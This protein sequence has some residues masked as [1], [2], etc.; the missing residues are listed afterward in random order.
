MPNSN[1][2]QTEQF[3]DALTAHKGTTVSRGDAK[4]IAKAAG[5]PAPRWFIASDVFRAGRGTYRKPTLAEVTKLG[6]GYPAKGRP[7]KS[8][9][10][11]SSAP[12]VK[13]TLPRTPRTVKAPTPAATD[14]TVLIKDSTANTSMQQ[15]LSKALGVDLLLGD[16]ESIPYVP[17]V[18][19]QYV[20]WGHFDTVKTILE[21]GQFLPFM[22]VGPSGNGKTKM[23]EQVCA[24]IGREFVRCNITAQTDEDDMLGGFRLVNGETKYVLGPVPLAMM[25]G[26]FL[27][28]DE[29]DLGTAAMMCLQPVLEGNAL[30]LKK[31]NKYILPAPGF[32]IGATSNTKGRGDD[33]K[34]AHTTIMNEA[35]LERFAVMFEQT[36]PE[37][38]TERKILTN[39]LKSLGVNDTTLAKHLVEFATVTRTNYANGLS[40]DEIATRRLLHIVRGYAALRDINKVMALT[41]ARFDADTATAF[42]NLWDAIHV[43]PVANPSPSGAPVPPVG[44]FTATNTTAT[45]AAAPPADINF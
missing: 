27:L 11:T 26:S 44:T 36:W 20:P 30:Y 41:L 43:D 28:L 33:G 22:I 1:L 15:E 6:L 5:L 4:R 29:V 16:A 23:P 14:Y 45:T 9:T 2:S 35:M 3:L 13:A 32:M 12:A 21:S 8:S 19:K 39:V 38:V 10:S 25:R 34:Y 40:S 42:K 7:R 24:A 17:P 18:D 31:I 37:A